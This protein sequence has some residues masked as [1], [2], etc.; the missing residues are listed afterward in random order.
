M[1]GGLSLDS[2]SVM[3]FD[4]ALEAPHPTV[5]FTFS[6]RAGY[7]AGA[8]RILDGLTASDLNKCNV[9]LQIIEAL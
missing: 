7:V 9:E 3:L 6:P 5:P 2:R 4:H 1:L 8:I